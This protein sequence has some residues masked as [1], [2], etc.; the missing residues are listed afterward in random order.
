MKGFT[1]IELLIMIVI[2]GIV[3]LLTIAVKDIDR[4]VASGYIKS[5]NLEAKVVKL[6]DGVTFI[7]NGIDG[8]IIPAENS[9]VW[10]DGWGTLFLG[11]PD[12]D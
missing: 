5:I 11:H 9:H 12:S 6:Q 10:L 8:Y 4:P 1:L 2:I 7:Y 3:A